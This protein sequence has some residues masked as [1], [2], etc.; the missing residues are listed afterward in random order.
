[1]KPRINTANITIHSAM[2]LLTAKDGR[3]LL[4]ITCMF[5]IY[6]LTSNAKYKKAIVIKGIKTL[7]KVKKK[8]VIR[9]FI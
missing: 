6:S 1:M 3:N 5:C 4:P 9:L 7:L 8:A 2:K